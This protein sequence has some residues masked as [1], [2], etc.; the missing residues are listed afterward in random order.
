[1]AWVL[2]VLFVHTGEGN[3]ATTTASFET[4]AL[5]EAGGAKMKSDLGGV[6]TVIDYSCVQA[7]AVQPAAQQP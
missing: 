2:I 5:C 7:K 6:F 3:V 4:Q 1:M